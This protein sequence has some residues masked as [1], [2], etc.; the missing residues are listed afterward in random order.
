MKHC[1]M[2]QGGHRKT[3]QTGYQGVHL[4]EGRE[5]GR[6]GGC[7][8]YLEWLKLPR[9]GGPDPADAGLTC[10]RCA[11]EP[12]PTTHLRCLQ[13]YTAGRRPCCLPLPKAGPEGRGGLCTCLCRHKLSSLTSGRR[14]RV[15][16]PWWQPFSGPSSEGRLPHGLHPRRAASCLR[17]LGDDFAGC[18][19]LRAGCRGTGS[20]TRRRVLLPARQHA[21]TSMSI[22]IIPVEDRNA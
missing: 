12:C 15:S 2:T 19:G 20:Q 9:L 14:T 1:F 8:C 16:F 11:P 6:I 17:Q 3:F 7:R 5:W 22:M 13:G 21:F 4:A 10:R 18:R